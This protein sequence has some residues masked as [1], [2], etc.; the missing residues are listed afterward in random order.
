MTLR[1]AVTQ[2]WE[3]WLHP[4]LLASPERRRA[5]QIISL[6]ALFALVFVLAQI[7]ILLLTGRPQRAPALLFLLA[8]LSCLAL[9]RLRPQPDA[10]GHVLLAASTALIS[11]AMAGE[12]QLYP[13]TVA[14]LGVICATAIM[15]L[16]A[17]VGLAWLAIDAA[18]VWL[19]EVL[20][21]KGVITPWLVPSPTLTTL[22]GVGLTLAFIVLALIFERTRRQALAEAE[23][24]TRSKSNFLANV[25]HELRTP[26]NGVLGLTE[27]LLR[28]ELAA[29]QREQ[30]ELL[31]RSGRSLVVLLNDLLDMSKVEAGKM[32][33]DPVDF[34]LRALLD[35]LLALHGPLAQARGLDFHFVA[36]TTLPGAVRGDA[37][38]MRQVLTNLI[39]NAIKF[40]AKGS[41]TLTLELHGERY[42][43]SV[44]D[45]GIGIAKESLPRL[46]SAF[47]QAEAGTT[48]RYGGTGLGLA[49]SRELVSLMG[50][51]LQV[52][53][54]LGVG[55]TLRF[56]VVL[57]TS[58][59]V[60]VETEPTEA[61]LP[62]APSLPVLVVDDNP[63]NL[64]VAC[65]LVEKAG[66]RTLTARDGAEALAAVQREPVGLVLMDCHMPVMDGF[67]ATEKIRS[68]DGDVALVPIIA[69][70]ASAMPEEL[71]RC[72]Q[73]GMND[74][75][76]KPV[77]FEQLNRTLRQVRAM[78]ELMNPLT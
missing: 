32:Q 6:A 65:G 29:P 42:D 39:S 55:T 58:H 54:E 25:S 21:W 24:L 14:W 18:L 23:R 50:G 70:T 73:A 66:Y 30:L 67:E 11:V 48:R 44:R 45:T 57:S 59:A 3:G 61:D 1:E 49:L 63:I 52:E 31:Q 38:R 12:D 36:P 37:M 19:I 27:L 46:F 47:A 74:C 68:L 10:A 16:G 78:H 62:S 4:A 33:L 9:L 77:T 28:S 51:A 41:V 64:R 20:R 72:R 71:E 26:M 13:G 35:D 5:A 34:D 40:T 53:S 69:L 8:P 2:K 22:R 76:I 60:L 7:V 56:S 75:L 15:T 17:R 43:F